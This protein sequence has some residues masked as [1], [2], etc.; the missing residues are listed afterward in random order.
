M[1]DLIIQLIN[2]GFIVLELDNFYVERDIHIFKQIIYNDEGYTAEKDRI[3]RVCTEITVINNINNFDIVT[4]FAELYNYKTYSSDS[5]FKKEYNPIIL[6]F[7]KI[8]K[9]F[10]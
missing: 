7:S 2:Q 5:A 8:K 9:Y 1:K 6:K 4:G 10:I 3:F